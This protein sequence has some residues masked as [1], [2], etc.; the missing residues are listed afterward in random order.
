MISSAIADSGC[1]RYDHFRG[2]GE[3]GRSNLA[4]AGCF[5]VRAEAKAGRKEKVPPCT[6]A[7]TLV[8]L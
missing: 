1:I 2:K 4:D 5:R 7:G 6:H 3:D 8:S